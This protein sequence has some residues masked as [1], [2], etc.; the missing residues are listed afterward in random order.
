M[1]IDSYTF[2][3][4]TVEGKAYNED[5]IIFPDKI[6]PNWWR[7]EG[8]SL[9]IEDLGEVIDYGPEVLVVGK[10]ASGCME[11]P[12]TTREALRE[13]HIEVIDLNTDEAWEVF[14]EQIKKG[15]KVVGAF[16]LTC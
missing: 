1:K 7:K 10:G 11:I 3:S 14:N 15:K 13:N 2:G 6:R 4:M 5:L 16:H 8:H 9:T 12:S